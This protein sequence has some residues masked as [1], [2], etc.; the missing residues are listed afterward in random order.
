MECCDSEF[1]SHA[2]EGNLCRE[3][4]V[5][6]FPYMEFEKKNERELELSMI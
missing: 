3:V 1:F 2:F 5:A 6:Y 4:S